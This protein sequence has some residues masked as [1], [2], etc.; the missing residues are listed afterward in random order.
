MA[1]VNDP[2]NIRS[3]TTKP[4]NGY[5]VTTEGLY[6]NPSS[7]GFSAGYC[8]RVARQISEVH[9]SPAVISADDI[10]FQAVVGHELIHAYHMYK[11]P[12]LPIGFKTNTERVAYQYSHNVY[13][14]NGQ[15]GSA[16]GAVKHAIFNRVGNCWGPYPSE[17]N[18]PPFLFK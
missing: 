3:F 6:Y 5:S 7:K 4:S 12:N 17:F 9:I 14:A 2:L 15:L 11:F 18:I 10:S 13:L 1:Q 8:I 16:M